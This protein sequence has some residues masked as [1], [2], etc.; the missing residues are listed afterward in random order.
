[1]PCS[2][3]SLNLVIN[4]AAK[5]NFEIVDFFSIVQELYN[6]FSASPLSNTRWQSCIEAIKLLK[7]N[8]KE[9]YKVLTEITD[10][11]TKDI[12]SRAQANNLI[13]KISS[14]KF[15]CSI[16]IWHDILIKINLVSKI[17]QNHTFNIQIVSECIEEITKELKDYRS[18]E[19]FEN[20]IMYIIPQR[21][22][23][24]Y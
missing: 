20:L 15:L 11:T 19:N 18:D 7:I 21:K 2:A 6:Y 3:H 24:I 5:I 16:I 10:D 17:M 9:I 4:D 1:V 12:E 14:F 22:W 23:L 13:L 8:I